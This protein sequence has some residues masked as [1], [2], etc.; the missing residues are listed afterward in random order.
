V[1]DDQALVPEALQDRVNGVV[2][3]RSVDPRLD[4]RRGQGPVRGPQRAENLRL[5][6]PGTSPSSGHAVT[7]Q[8]IDPDLSG[9][10]VR[11][12]PPLLLA[13]LL[14]TLLGTRRRAAR[15]DRQPLPSCINLLFPIKP[16]S[17]TVS[18]AP[19][20]QRRPAGMLEDEV[21]VALWRGGRP[22]SP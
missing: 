10:F 13:T 11:V 17:P 14:G 19:E 6:L 22:M 1:A 15:A 18:H 7:L 9:H 4:L 8:V 12:L 16:R 20:R 3:E 5:E 21:L 2:G